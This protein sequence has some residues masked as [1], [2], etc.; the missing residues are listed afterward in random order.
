MTTIAM[1]INGKDRQAEADTETRLIDVLRYEFGLTGTKLGC[2]TGDCGAC[3]V[4]MDGRAVNSCLVYACECDGARIE[5]IE[6]VTETPVGK[7]IVEEMIE[8]DGAQCGFCTPGIVVTACALLREQGDAALSDD[9][10]A[11]ALAGNLCRCTGYLPI[12]QAMRRAAD[13]L[14]TEAR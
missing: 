8:A 13:Q 3:T 14:A 1:Q 9:Q 11:T 2:A 10:I 7:V 4:V 12:R 6:G 5:T